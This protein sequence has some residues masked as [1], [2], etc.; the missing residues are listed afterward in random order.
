MKLLERINAAGTTVVMATHDRNIVDRLQKRVVV[1]SQGNI[2]SDRRDSGYESQATKPA[3]RKGDTGAIN[4]VTDAQDSS[5]VV[6]PVTE[7]TPV[8]PVVI[9]PIDENAPER[10]KTDTKPVKIVAV[11]ARA[12]SAEN[13][14]ASEDESQNQNSS[15]DGNTK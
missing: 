8:E 10:L 4:L 12:E 11:A 3:K 9:N 2:I 15:N 13:L 5:V 7:S 1:L 14:E 6:T